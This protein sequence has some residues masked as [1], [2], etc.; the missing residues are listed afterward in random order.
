MK[1]EKEASDMFMGIKRIWNNQFFR[2]LLM[3]A[4]LVLGVFAFQRALVLILRTEY[5]LTTPES[6]SM[7]PT[8]KKGDLL[9]IQGGFE[10]KDINVG[11]VIVFKDPRGGSIP[12]VHRVV[13]KEYDETRG[14]WI[15][16]TKGDNNITSDPWIVR[17][18]YIYGKV[19]FVIPYLG[20]IKIY[21]G[22]E[23]G[24]ALTIILL[25][26]LLLLENWD[27]LKSKDNEKKEK[28]NNSLESREE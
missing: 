15:F 3:L 17:E 14:E 10:G 22:N 8:I 11:D 13:Y 25:V 5:P 9:I 24:I 18:N 1:D 6:W 26:A 4:V 7:Y 27:L 28:T 16:K 20:Y 12:I 19:I 21:L 23:I 2:S